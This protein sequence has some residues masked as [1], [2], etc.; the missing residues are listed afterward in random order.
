MSDRTGLS[1][2][3]TRSRP[4]DDQGRRELDRHV[5]LLHADLGRM[6]RRQLAGES[7]DY[8]LDSGALVNEAYLRLARQRQV[9]WQ[10]GAHVLGIAACCMRRIRIDTVRRRQAVKRPLVPVSLDET[11]LTAEPTVVETLVARE[12]LDWLATRDRRQAAIVELRFFDGCTVEEIAQQMGI[13]P[14]TAKRGLGAGLRALKTRLQMVARPPA[15]MSQRR[16]LLR[17]SCRS[18]A[19]PV[20]ATPDATAAL[21]TR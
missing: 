3:G 5:A 4:A 19:T 14:A 9:R 17:V 16:P 10:D 12:A 15:P 20:R 1:T 13:S 8:T 2:T 6:A 18:G 21:P 7:W 11:V